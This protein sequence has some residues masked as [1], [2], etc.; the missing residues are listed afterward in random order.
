MG[1]FQMTFSFS[2]MVGPWIGALTLDYFG[3]NILCNG[4]FVLGIL[5]TLLFLLLKKNY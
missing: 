5:S 1:Y 4:A 2:L 3:H